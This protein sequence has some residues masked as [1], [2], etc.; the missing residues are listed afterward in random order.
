M[1][2]SK[3]LLAEVPHAEVNSAARAKSPKAHRTFG[4]VRLIGDQASRCA[5]RIVAAARMIAA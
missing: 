3:P 4:D 2:G 1:A 5:I